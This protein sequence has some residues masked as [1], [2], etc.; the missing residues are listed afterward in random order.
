M[1]LAIQDKV[2]SHHC[3]L[4]LKISPLIGVT[5]RMCYGVCRVCDR[6]TEALLKSCEH[7]SV[8]LP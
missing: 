3:N 7:E 6:E 1:Q 2:S 5:Y 4:I 8:S